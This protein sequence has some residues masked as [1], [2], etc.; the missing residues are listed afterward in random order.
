MSGVHVLSI[1]RVKNRFLIQAA[2]LLLLLSKY[3]SYWLNKPK[4]ARH[5]HGHV[6][7]KGFPLLIPTAGKIPT[8]RFLL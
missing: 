7:V 3:S 6:T 8:F 1:S 4:P 2:F 5:G